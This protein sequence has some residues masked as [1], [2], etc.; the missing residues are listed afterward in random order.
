MSNETPTTHSHDDIKPASLIE[1]SDYIINDIPPLAYSHGDLYYYNG[2]FYEELNTHGIGQY[3]YAFYLKYA[4]QLW[5]PSKVDN[6]IKAIKHHPKIKQVN[7]FDYYE[8]L[9]NINNGVYDFDAQKLLP[10]S[11]DYL[12]TACVDVNYDEN[13][14]D[15]P[16][17]VRIVKDIFKNPDNSYDTES[18]ENIFKLGGYLIYPQVKI[19]QLF[20]FY[21]EGSNGKSIIMDDIYQMFFDKKFISALSLNTLSKESSFTRAK[22]MTSR[23]NFATEQK[24]DVIESEELKKITDGSNISIERKFK[25]S[26]TFKPK[27]KIIV[28]CNNLPKFKDSTYGTKRRLFIIK[29]KNKFITSKRLYRTIQNPQEKRIYLA[30]N[31]DELVAKLKEEKSAI[32]NIFLIALKGLKENN[33]SFTE[34]ENMSEVLKEYNEESDPAGQWLDAT[35][36]LDENTDIPARGFITLVEIMDKYKDWYDDNYHDRKFM[37]SSRSMGKKIRDIFRTEGI[38]HFYKKSNGAYSTTIAFNLV[39]KKDPIWNLI[40][41]EQDKPNL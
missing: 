28:A 36:T 5:N 27:T 2:K 1:L 15:A 23:V 3:V 14:K 30:A 25:E 9:I 38:M 13:S 8:N 20:L 34:S 16:N 21:G 11:S 10:H 22:L 12:F 41:P 18:I 35:F 39:V 19:N 40:E 32:F 17:F 4:P 31:R 29:F 24:A 6:I 33:W 26:I 7:E 37:V